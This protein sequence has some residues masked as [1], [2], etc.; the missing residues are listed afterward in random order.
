MSL[1]R[2]LSFRREPSALNVCDRG[3]RY[4]RVQHFLLVLFSSSERD[5]HLGHALLIKDAREQGFGNIV[6]VIKGALERARAAGG[7]AAHAARWREGE[8]CESAEIRYLWRL[9][10]TKK[11]VDA[12][13][14]QQVV[15]TSL[16][17]VVVLSSL[18][19][20]KRTETSGQ[21]RCKNGRSKRTCGSVGEEEVTHRL[22]TG[23]TRGRSC[24]SGTS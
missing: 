12:S 17:L 20:N 16:V 14:T 21:E 8:F 4:R 6:A 13:V 5:S 22:R 10:K 18:P 19:R 1:T 11:L 15:T 9:K 3:K 7:V 23:W 24:R 2:F